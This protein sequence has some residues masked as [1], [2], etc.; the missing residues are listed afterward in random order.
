[1]VG[2]PEGEQ[3]LRISVGLTVQTRY[4]RVTDKNAQTSY[5]GI[6]RAMHTRRV[7]KRKGPNPQA[8]SQCKRCAEKLHSL[9]TVYYL[10]IG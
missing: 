5:H 9:A 7:I 8:I 6:V 2:L 3:F 4:R 1:M 10:T